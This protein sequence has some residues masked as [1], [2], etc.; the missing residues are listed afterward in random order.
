MLTYIERDKQ[1]G[2]FTRKP[3]QARP[4]TKMRQTTHCHKAEQQSRV[5]GKYN[6]KLK[7][8]IRAYRRDV[9]S[10]PHKYT[11]QRFWSKQL[12]RCTLAKSKCTR[13]SVCFITFR[14]NLILCT[15]QVLNWDILR[16]P[17]QKPRF[18]TTAYKI[19]PSLRPKSY[20]EL[21]IILLLVLLCEEA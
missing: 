20:A 21:K 9:Q 3:T 15:I 13:L 17:L 7:T 19:F 6:I 11:H 10:T 1:E 16:S 12:H 14:L 2:Q 4:H 8:S 5:Y 18:S